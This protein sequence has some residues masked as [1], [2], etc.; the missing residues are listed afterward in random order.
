MPHDLILLHRLHGIATVTFNKPEQLNTIDVE[1][2]L[3]FESVIADL[4][5][6]P[7]IKVIVL[8]GNGRTFGAGGAITA[9]ISSSENTAKE[10]IEPMHRSI[11]RLTT[12][13]AIVIGSLQG[14]IAGGSMSLALACDLTIAAD[15]ATFNLAYA[16][17]GASCDL[18]GSW[19]LPRLIGLRRSL[20][21]ALLSTTLSA[22]E[23][24]EYGLINRM[25]TTEDLMQETMTIAEKLANG[26]TL[27][28]AKLK[29]LLRT[30]FNQSLEEQLNI[31]SEYF[32]ASSKT[33]DF[34]EAI[35]A[36]FE[37]RPPKFIGE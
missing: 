22:K 10:I 19:H 26:P 13:D 3:Q 33:K 24:L 30:S 20:E 16:K 29:H 11:I 36:F 34:K 12:M 1:M 14:N 27:A 4:E 5:K 28:H 37:K 2:A 6:D 23:A 25:V 17:I 7:S 9:F 15:S 32:Q 8:A 31:E 18:G 21:I 35:H